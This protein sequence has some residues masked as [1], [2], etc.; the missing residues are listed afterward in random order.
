MVSLTGFVFAARSLELGRWSL[1]E[2]QDTD[3]EKSRLGLV[4]L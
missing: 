3:E 4:C 1:Y 2:N